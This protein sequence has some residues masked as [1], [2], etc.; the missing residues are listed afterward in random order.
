MNI[1]H[2][3]IIIN[4]GIQKSRNNSLKKKITQISISYGKGL[5]TLSYIPITKLPLTYALT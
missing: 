3:L 2:A 5:L 1:T 4:L